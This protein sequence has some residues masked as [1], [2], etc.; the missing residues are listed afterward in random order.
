MATITLGSNTYN[1]VTPPASPGFT[2][3]QVSMMDAVAVVSSPFVP[4]QQQTQAWPGAD[5]WSLKLSLPKMHRLH[6]APWIGFLG[7]MR[8]MS[9]VVQLGDPLGAQPQGSPGGA[10]VAS[11]SGLLNALGATALATRGW[12]ASKYR[13]LQP[14]DYIQVVNRL[15]QAVTE[16]DSDSSGDATINIWPSLRE[17][18]ADGTAL[19]LNNCQGVFRLASNLRSWHAAVDKLA[20]ISFTFT[21]VR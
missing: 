4:S 17:T 21:E 9:N 11:T 5:A 7:G 6:A 3:I 15:Y 2:D 12:P 18:P 19:K 13:L 16:V 20:E 8:G 10:P 14:G 1:L